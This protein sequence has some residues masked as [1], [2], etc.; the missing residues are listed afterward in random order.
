MIYS[1]E[2]I[3]LLAVDLLYFLIADKFNTIDESNS[4]SSHYKH[5]VNPVFFS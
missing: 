1:V 3:L 5:S 4:R 2:F